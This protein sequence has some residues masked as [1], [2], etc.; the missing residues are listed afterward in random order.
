MRQFSSAKQEIFFLY[1]RSWY[2]IVSKK[3]S[4]WK[5]RMDFFFHE[6]LILRENMI[7]L[8]IFLRK[9][10]S[11]NSRCMHEFQLRDSVRKTYKFWYGERKLSRQMSL[12]SWR[13]TLLTKIELFFNFL[14]LLYL[15]EEKIFLWWKW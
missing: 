10:K 9:Q 14:L 15:R 6:T 11:S 5:N 3:A 13:K 7:S 4:E 12:E 2:I 8:S 1:H